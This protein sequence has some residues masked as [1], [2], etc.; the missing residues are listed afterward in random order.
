MKAEFRYTLREL[1]QEKSLTQLQLAHELQYTQ[2]N[3]SEWEKGTVEPKATALKKIANFFNVSI[4]YLLG[5]SDDF[6]NIVIKKE[7]PQLS[8]EELKIIEDFRE[9]NTSGKK[10]VKQTIETLRTT[11]S[12]STQIKRNS[13]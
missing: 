13:N 2:S 3:I 12:Q 5:N 1:R 4:D 7:T 6:G 8:A 10:L 9:L 11:S